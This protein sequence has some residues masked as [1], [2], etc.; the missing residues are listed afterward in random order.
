MQRHKYKR[1][2]RNFSVAWGQATLLLYIDGLAAASYRFTR[3]MHEN[4]KIFCISHPVAVDSVTLER[5]KAVEVSSKDDFYSAAG[6][7]STVVS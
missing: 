7:Y 5:V 2:C 3:A 6:H 1:H 4:Q